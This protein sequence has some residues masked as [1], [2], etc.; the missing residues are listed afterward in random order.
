MT[1]SIIAGIVGAIV[2]VLLEVVPGLKE[3]WSEWEWKPL[4]LFGLFE[5][6][7]LVAWALTCFAGMAIYDVPDCTW[8]G[9]L[10]VMSVGFVAFMASQTTFTLAT[11]KTENARAR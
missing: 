7:P 6:V 11:R 5:A 9:A 1:A 10:A 4:T 2:S 3:R 8:Q